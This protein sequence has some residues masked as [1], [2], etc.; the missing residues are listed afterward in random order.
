MTAV[1]LVPGSW[2]GAWAYDVVR[3]GLDAEGVAAHAIDLPS[4]ASAQA[5]L[6][7]DAAAVRRAL[8]AIAAPT[9]VVGHS[10]G[11]VA[12]SEGAAGAPNA[13]GLVYLCAF[14]LDA[15][16]SLL[17]AMQHELPPWIAVDEAASTCLPHDA[18][19]ALFGDCSAEVAALA[20]QRL[21]PQALGALAAPQTA[22]A[23]RTL[24]STYVVCEA[25]R[26]VPPPAQ[27]AMAAHAGRVEYLDSSHSPFLSQPLAVVDLICRALNGRG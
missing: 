19:R 3:A 18:E 5:G 16:R 20:T 14:L 24:P 8:D 17:D 6:R 21:V 15:G 10:Y 26:A 4:N 13:V 9:V 12:V 22:A 23:W 2:H 1:L 25:D 11:G 7:D 27:A